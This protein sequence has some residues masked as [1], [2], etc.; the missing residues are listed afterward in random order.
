MI[1]KTHSQRIKAGILRK[2]Q[3]DIDWGKV[4]ARSK[5]IEQLK[6]AQRVAELVAELYRIFKKH[7]QIKLTTKKR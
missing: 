4:L 1:R 2:K 6:D 7:G 5:R 3:R